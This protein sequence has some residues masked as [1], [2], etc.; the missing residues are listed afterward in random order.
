[1]PDRPNCVSVSVVALMNVATSAQSM[2]A[3]APNS[4]A[5]RAGDPPTASSASSAAVPAAAAVADAQAPLVGRVLPPLG[6]AM[7]K[8]TASET[9]VTPAAHQVTGRMD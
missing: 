1:M 3:E 9:Q 7:A 4:A 6:S 5:R 8:K 2:E